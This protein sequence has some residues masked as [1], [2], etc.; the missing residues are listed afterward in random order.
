[1]EASKRRAAD[2]A[3][4]EA[5]QR[6]FA[7]R[8]TERYGDRFSYLGGYVSTHCNAKPK[9]RCKRCGH[10]FNRYVDWN[11]EIRCPEC[12][13]REVEARREAKA[14]EIK[15]HAVC[16]KR[17]EECGEAFVT[18]D[19]RARRCSDR[20][21]RKN[22]NRKTKERRKRIGAN[23]RANHRKRARKY[24]VEYDPTVTLPKL[25]ERDGMTCYLC[26]EECN[27]SD[28]AW[29][30]NGPTYPTIDHVIAMANGG[31]HT[32]GNVKVAHALCNSEKRDLM[33][34]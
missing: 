1:M 9:L 24:G 30:T 11:Y 21:R 3:K 33:V 26:G 17:C 13:R 31:G 27:P 8:F 25:I 28:K 14:D 18:K 12:Y 6:R 10:E 4:R 22:K 23:A 19:V 32:W 5:G 15:R 20:C 7:E 16:F 29:G 2:E 34:N